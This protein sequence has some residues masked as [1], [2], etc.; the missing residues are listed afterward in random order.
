MNDSAPTMFKKIFYSVI[1]IYHNASTE[2][3]KRRYFLLCLVFLRTEVRRCG[4]SVQV[5]IRLDL[6]SSRKQ[7]SRLLVKGNEMTK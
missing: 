5:Q 6:T 1:F 2:R 4:I 7:C 3:E